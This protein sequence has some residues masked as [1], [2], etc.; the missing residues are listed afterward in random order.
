MSGCRQ[1]FFEPLYAVTQQNKVC[2]LKRDELEIASNDLGVVWENLA[3]LQNRAFSIEQLSQDSNT[4][5]FI[6]PSTPSDAVEGLGLHIE[7]EA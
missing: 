5:L 7:N 4:H 2:A 1:R 6:S 3:P